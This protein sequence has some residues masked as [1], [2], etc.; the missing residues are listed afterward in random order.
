MNGD[1]T[2]ASSLRQAWPALAALILLAGW[3]GAGARSSAGAKAHTRVLQ[4]ATQPAVR[5]AARTTSA[6]TA[7]RRPGPDLPRLLGQMIVAR[8]HGPAPSAPF[9]ARIRA[10]QIGGVILFGDNVAGGVG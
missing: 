3:G 10:G 1:S 9:L 7:S 8:F 5:T 2:G 6:T 4:T